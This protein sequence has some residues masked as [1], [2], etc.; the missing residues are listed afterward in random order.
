MIGALLVWEI[1][2]MPS[3]LRRPFGAIGGDVVA[4]GITLLLGFAAL[5]RL[6][7]RIRRAGM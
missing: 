4:L 1:D 6:S 7:R 2:M 5:R 3:V